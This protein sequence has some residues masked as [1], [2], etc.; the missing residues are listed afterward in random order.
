MGYAIVVDTSVA[1]SA[2]TSGKPLPEACRKVLAAIYNYDH[3][4]AISKSVHAEWMKPIQGRDGQR[5]SYASLIA[6]QWLKDMQS[7]G[8]VENVI[9]EVNSALRQRALQGLKSNPQVSSS[10]GPVEKDFHLVETALLSNNR[11]ISLDAR[12]F[13]HLGNLQEIANEVCAVMWVNPVQQNAADW[14]E[15]GANDKPEYHVCILSG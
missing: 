15:A 13:H 10:A 3:K 8:R 2:G 6:I 5:R 12:M 9:L 14:L 1:R 4:V 11:V 7:A